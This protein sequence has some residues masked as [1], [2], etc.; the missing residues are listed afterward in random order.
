MSERKLG[1]NVKRLMAFKVSRD[2]IPSGGG[3]EDGIKALTTPGRMSEL[4]R[5]A[6]VWVDEAIAVMRTAHDNPYGD[7]EEIIAGAILAEIEKRENK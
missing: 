1:P 5:N 4:S 7:D 2:A 3:F 6:L